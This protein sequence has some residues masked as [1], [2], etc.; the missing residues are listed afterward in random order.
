MTSPTLSHG[1]SFADLYDRDGLVRLDAAFV[2]WLKSGQVEMHARLMAARCGPG[3]LAPKDESNLLIDLA[4]PLEDFLSSLF[5]VASEAAELRAHH[6]SLAPL[7]D[8]KRLFVQRYV[9]RAIKPEVAATF[10]GDAVT[11]A[12]ALPAL[13]ERGLEAW[14]LAFAIATRDL[15][16]SDFKVA[17]PTP[18]IE[19]LARYAAWALHAPAG[20]A[21]HR[22]GP[23]FKIPHKLDFEHLVPVETEVVDG[24]TRMRLPQRMLRHREGF[25][26]TDQGFDLVRALDHANYCIWCH[27][28]GKDSCSRG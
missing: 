20:K 4:R 15:L 8:C 26:L 9:A 5:G 1:L 10:D 7:Y 18:A 21:R 27:N 6:N 11:A 28:Q 3:A 2:D 13:A 22:E 12:I 24:V 23:L 19:A 16:G 25:S 14:E 17:T